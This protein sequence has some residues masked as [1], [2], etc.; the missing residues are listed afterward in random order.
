MRYKF[1]FRDNILSKEDTKKKKLS[2]PKGYCFVKD[3]EEKK[4]YKTYIP[5]LNLILSGKF[6]GGIQEYGITQLAGPSDSF[7]SIVGLILVKSYLE[8]NPNGRVVMY[9]TEGGVSPTYFAS[10]G[11]Q[12]YVDANRIIVKTIGFVEELKNEAYNF[13]ES[14]VKSGIEDNNTLLF[15]DGIGMLPSKLELDNSENDKTA[16]D[17]KRS[18]AIKSM[19]R[20]L[21]GKAMEAKCPIVVVNHS[22]ENFGMYITEQTKLSGGGGSKN[23]SE[24]VLSFSKKNKKGEDDVIYNEV[25]IEVLKSRTVAPKKKV[26]LLVHPENGMMATGYLMEKAKEHG[27][28]KSSGAW[29][30]LIDPTTGEIFEYNG[31]KSFYEKDVEHDVKFWKFVF[32]NTNFKQ[33]VEKEYN[34]AKRSALFQEGEG[35]F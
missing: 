27:Y 1:L 32:T 31:Q 21:T 8:N 23:S 35:F 7:K 18:Q 6:D 2:L 5:A 10:T 12:H 19:F 9:D 26:V 34:L 20:T 16:P 15:I 28:I 24:T 14:I 11:L 17:L 13:L 30:S 3:V 33:D 29:K 25:H 22:Y 4:L